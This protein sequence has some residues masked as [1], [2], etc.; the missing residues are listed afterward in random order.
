M[1]SF[2]FRTISSQNQ[3]RDSFANLPA[4]I[5]RDV[6]R[7]GPL[8]HATL[9][10][11]LSSSKLP[12]RSSSTKTTRHALLPMTKC[13][14]PMTP[15]NTILR[16]TSQPSLSNRT[17]HG[18]EPTKPTSPGASWR[19]R[20]R[21]CSSSSVNLR[22]IAGAGLLDRGSTWS[23]LRACR[24]WRYHPA[25]RSRWRWL[26]DHRLMSGPHRSESTPSPDEL[27]RLRHRQVRPHLHELLRLRLRHRQVRPH[28]HE[29]LRLPQH[30]MRSGRRQP[31]RRLW[32]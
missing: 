11:T 8:S 16:T 14:A 4:C 22:G 17:K 13:K 19:T 24:S 32:G 1:R 21:A 15:S 18:D 26:E 30:A 20:Q 2:N 31:L 28:P 5:I 23:A 25:R 12:A 9:T 29:L 10:M 3:W 27:L 7:G 6:D